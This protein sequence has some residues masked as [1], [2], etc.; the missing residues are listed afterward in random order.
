MTERVGGV[1][2]E[3]IGP[4]IRRTLIEPG[5]LAPAYQDNAAKLR[6]TLCAISR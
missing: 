4:C 6:D 2:R 5:A 1:G 3:G